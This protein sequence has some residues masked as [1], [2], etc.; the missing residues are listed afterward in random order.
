MVNLISWLG[1]SLPVLIMYC[2]SKAGAVLTHSENLDKTTFLASV[3]LD[4][5]S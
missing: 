2:K 3:M 1:M 4:Y 5:T